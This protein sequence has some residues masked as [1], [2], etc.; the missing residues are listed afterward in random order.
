MIRLDQPPGLTIVR[1]RAVAYVRMSTEH[2]QYSTC[3]QLDVINGFA[4]QRDWEIE[5]VYSDEG[6]SGLKIKGRAAL[7]QM[8]GDVLTKKV[9]FGHILVYDVSRWGRFQD[10]DE[11]AH[12]EFICRQAGVAVHYCAEQFENDGDLT[13]TIAKSFKR[14]MAGEYSRELSAKVFQGACRMIRMGYKQGGSAVFGL[15]RMLV[16]AQGEHKT[17]LQ[18]GE[19]KCLH[20]DRVI[21]VPGPADER[22]MVRWI[23]EAF[24]LRGVG[25]RAI[26]RQLNERGSVTGTGRPWNEGAVR[27]VLKNENYI[28]NLVYHRTSTKLLGP[29]VVNPPG[30]WVRKEN[31]FPGMVPRE[32][33][34]KAQQI[35]QK[36]RCQF[37]DEDMLE[38]LKTIFKQ[39]GYL[40]SSLIDKA[41]P[42]P[43][44]RT[45]LNRFGSLLEAYRVVGFNPPR[46]YDHLGVTR[47]LFKI[48]HELIAGLIQ[49]IE[50]HGATATWSGRS[51]ILHINNELRVSVIF[52]RHRVTD[53]G[54]SRWRIRR[55]SLV[56]PDLTMA[57]RMD[58][59][60]ER[61]QDYFL[62]PA[63]ELTRNGMFLAERNGIYLDAYRFKSLDFLVGMAA[64]VK[65]S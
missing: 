46:D 59:K 53:F 22:E 16:D 33:F 23:F 61:I 54:S 4:R 32:W 2:Q 21:Y 7:S 39:H 43:N 48:N 18:R 12:Y 34:L 63:M 6:K 35:F 57:V 27:R 5:K 49:E 56:K 47:R 42:G 52:V 14:A 58:H 31:A 37:T 10:P 29:R 25:A 41:R 13:S 17:I 28:G 50:C 24:V 15:R 65:F 44:T 19:Q 26:A 60:N 40:S 9:N 55:R 62:L 20:T 11:A 8:I 3:N 45:Y 1:Q 64:R 38:N 30:Q 51:H 36:R